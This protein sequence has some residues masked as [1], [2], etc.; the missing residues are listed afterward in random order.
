MLSALLYVC[1]EKQW[2]RFSWLCLGATFF[3]VVTCET[4]DPFF[5]GF[6]MMAVATTIVLMS[7]RTYEDTLGKT[8]NLW[9]PAAILN[10]GGLGGTIALTGVLFF[11]HTSLGPLEWS[12]FALLSLASIA[13]AF[14][15]EKLYGF[16]PCVALGVSLFL[17][18]TSTYWGETMVWIFLCFTLIYA[19]S[20]YVLMGWRPG[21]L[22]WPALAVSSLAFYLIFYFVSDGGHLT[23]MT[24]VLFFWGGLA[25]I[26]AGLA[27]FTLYKRL[28]E[29][30][31]T[32]VSQ[33]E[34]GIFASTAALFVALGIGVECQHDFLGIAW[35][36][37]MALI[38]WLYTRYDIA[39]LRILSLCLAGVVIGLF[40]FEAFLAY[41]ER[42]FYILTVQE[43]PLLL[44]QP[45]AQLAIPT[46]FFLGTSYSLRQ[47]KDDAFVRA[48]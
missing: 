16:L 34:L 30:S 25:F 48:L 3:W 15:Q 9:T 8:Q 10:Y 24:K 18:L 11:N 42:V 14:F 39:A 2:W 28:Q 17:L 23:Y 36:A 21:S 47:K 37:E 44:R 45:F 29:T 41:H 22:L 33:R 20:G 40:L 38:A 4:A 19:G 35:A 31:D 46:L 32:P 26:L 27:V 43:L 12:L 6:F 7:R 13:L 5:A 1:R